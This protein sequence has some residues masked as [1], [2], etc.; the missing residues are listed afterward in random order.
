MAHQAE[1]L[2]AEQAIEMLNAALQ[3]QYRSAQEG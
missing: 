1:R 3:L 2:D